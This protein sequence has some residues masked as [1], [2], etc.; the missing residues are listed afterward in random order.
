MEPQG[1][2][3]DVLKPDGDDG[4]GGVRL[5]PLV[6][7]ADPEVQGAGRD[8]QESQDNAGQDNR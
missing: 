8:D 2:I 4:G 7:P 6:I 1:S 3:I 5:E